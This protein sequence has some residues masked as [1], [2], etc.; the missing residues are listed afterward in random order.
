VHII[1]APDARAEAGAI[2]LLMR[3]TLQ[4]PDKTAALVTR[5]RKL[6]RR[7]AAELQRWGI[8]VDDSAGTPL[9]QGPV[10]IW[11]RQILACAAEDFAPV[12]LLAL[13]KHPKTCLVRHDDVANHVGLA[14]DP[15]DEA[16]DK[17]AHL[18]AVYQLEAAIL[19]GV[20]PPA[21]KGQGL[22]GLQAAA[23]TAGHDTGLLD[24]LAHAFAPLTSLPEAAPMAEHMQALMAV[25]QVLSHPT[26]QLLGHDEEGRA[27][28][29]LSE[30]LSAHSVLAGDIEKADWPALFDMW[31]AR[32]SLRAQGPTHDRL[33]LWGA[34]E[35]RL[36]QAD[37]MILGGLNETVWPPMP[38]TGPWLSR[39]MRA[40]LQMSQPERQIGL[41]AHDFVQGASAPLVYLTRA[42]KIDNAPS[43][44]ARW[45]RR[46]ETLYGKQKRDEQNRL[47]AWWR[48]LDHNPNE[49]ILAATQPAPC[50]PISARPDRLSVTQIETLVHN[51]Y[52]IYARKILRL[53]PWDAVDTPPHAGHRGTLIHAILEQLV[54]RDLHKGDAVAQSVM[55]LADELQGQEPGGA[56][57][58]AYWQARLK[59]MGA[60]LADHF[61]AQG[62][63]VDESFVEQRGQWQMN[64]D[65]A[66]FTLSAIADRIDRRK[67]GV[68]DIID[69]K[70]GAMPSRKDVDEHIAPQL[71]LEAAML[72]AGGFAGLGDTLNADIGKLSYVHVT[73]RE[74][75]GK[76]MDVPASDALIDAASHMVHQLI[77]AYRQPSQPYLVHVR[78][79]AKQAG[80]PN[81]FDHLARVKEWRSDSELGH[82]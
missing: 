47:L 26:K 76:L 77:A 56:A 61:A 37:V 71:T 73:G 14:H 9:T 1:E 40:A 24:A 49:Q 80:A 82:G 74:P 57:I 34:L 7:V 69:Y 78:P 39:P 55:Q 21:T 10:T 81:M 64:I 36:M 35:A 67:D 23:Q 45:L 28:T 12:A 46:L 79:K 68:F 25:A 58:L 75:A 72:W 62:D 38:E 11:L 43:V 19:R 4:K 44:A 41:A 3:E 54:A 16:R 29:A 17:A 22:A 8:K 60:W 30:Q 18:R 13:L 63:N 15:S 33:H 51:P 2:A 27:L 20:R 65:G 50:P 42:K 48:S 5:D 70:T 59:A 32:E 52:E 6:A 31:L 53:R 66:P